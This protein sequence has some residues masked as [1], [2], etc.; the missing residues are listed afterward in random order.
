PH[1]S[2][3]RSRTSSLPSSLL[4]LHNR[5]PAASWKKLEDTR[6]Y[7]NGNILREYQLEGVN[8]L[9]NCILADEMGLGKTIQSIEDVE[10]NLAPKQE[11]IIEVGFQSTYIFIKC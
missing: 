9:Q 8:W 6:E 5:P 11:T 2:S 3:L 7:K 1:S 10:K 4:P